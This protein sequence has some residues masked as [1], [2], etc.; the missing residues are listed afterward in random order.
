MHKLAI[1]LILFSLSSLFLVSFTDSFAKTII[2][3]RQQWKEMTDIDQLTCNEGLIL[4]QK[5]NGSPAC[6]SSNTYLKL[7]DR[8]YG[9]FDSSIIVKRPT[10]ADLLMRDLATN[11]DLMSHW[12]EMMQNDPTKMSKTM[13]HMVQLMKQ[14][15]EYL[16][17]M[18]GPI[19]SENELQ[20]K[21][22]EIMKN[23]PHMEQSMHNNPEWME[24]VHKSMGGQ[25]M[26]HDMNRD[27]EHG[28]NM[29]MGG[30]NTNNMMAHE[31]FTGFSNYDTMMDMMHHFWINTE[32]S[33]D[34]H[35]HMLSNSH[36]MKQMSGEMMETML[37]HMMD[38]P[39]M[40]QKM[41]EYL[42]EHEEFMNSIRHEN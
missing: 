4:L 24:S 3:P 9:Q 5:T 13:Q 26:G 25:E 21:M 12:H 39:E 27:I 14:N 15:P 16:D 35:E 36:H 31:K 20:S 42:L 34:L 40:R 22:I 38:D 1:F 37:G 8:G 28:M 2:P 19:I 18:L 29:T 32:L 33:M 23:H 7:I 11:K 30:H 17:N 10:M 6:V 41:I